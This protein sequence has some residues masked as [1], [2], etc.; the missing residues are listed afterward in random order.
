MGPSLWRL[1][2]TGVGVGRARGQGRRW[3]GRPAY[4]A[5][6]EAGSTGD[7][8]P[9][10]VAGTPDEAEPPTDFLGADISAGHPRRPCAQ[11]LHGEMG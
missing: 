9:D 5:Q 10:G 11:M 7:K 3:V 8:D 2:K 1:G 6:T 4:P